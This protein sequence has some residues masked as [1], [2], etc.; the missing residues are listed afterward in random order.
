M[1]FMTVSVGVFAGAKIA[2][3]GPLATAKARS[4]APVPHRMPVVA[5]IAGISQILL[6]LLWDETSV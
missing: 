3:M 2:E 6:G 1:V 5:R 4:T